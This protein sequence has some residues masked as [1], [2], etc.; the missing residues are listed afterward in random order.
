MTTIRDRLFVLEHEFSDPALDGV[1]YCKDCVTV[2]GLLA[3]FPERAADLEV[4]RVPWP[5]PR[6]AVVDAL[7]EENQNLPALAFAEGGVVNEIEALLS[8]LHSRHGFPKR[9]P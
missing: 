4:V 5:R 6:Q 8:A 7:G 3:L 9:H 1:Y 2:E